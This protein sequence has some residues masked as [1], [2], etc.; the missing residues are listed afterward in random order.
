MKGLG[1]TYTNHMGYPDTQAAALL[2]CD[3]I[4]I[5]LRWYEA[6]T[7][8]LGVI[9]TVH[10]DPFNVAS[11]PIPMDGLSF[12][13]VTVTARDRRI[14]SWFYRNFPLPS[15]DD[16]AACVARFGLPAPPR[17]LIVMDHGTTISVT[18]KP[19]GKEY[20]RYLNVFVD[21][22]PK[23]SEDL[24]RNTYTDDYSPGSAVRAAMSTG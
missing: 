17:H 18:L 6:T 22:V 8:V 20:N 4:G 13:V 9:F 15:A 7:R 1:G 11:K 16:W 5:L 10:W 21:M 12:T 2:L 14:V 19:Q 23:W 3:L 24:I